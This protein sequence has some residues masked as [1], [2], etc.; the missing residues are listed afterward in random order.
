MTQLVRTAN[1][2]RRHTALI[3]FC[4]LAG[5]FSDP[6]HQHTSWTSVPITDVGMVAGEWEGVVIKGDDRL[7]SGSVRVTIRENG[8]Y[9]FT[10]QTAE[11]V[12]VGAG[13][14]QARDGRLVG[15]SD[16]RAVTVLLYN[17]KGEAIL[18]VES[19]N[20]ETGEHYQGDFTKVQ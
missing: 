17:H 13:M 9:L 18:T 19:I 6:T 14:L 12:A 2:L 7:P 15:D 3:L 10:G 8:S 20:H 16:R 4:L 11:K 1:L 5:C